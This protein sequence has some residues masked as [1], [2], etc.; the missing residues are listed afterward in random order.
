MQSVSSYLGSR[1]S[2]WEKPISEAVGKKI[3]FLGSSFYSF[4][5]LFFFLLAL[6]VCCFCCNVIPV[7]KRNALQ[8]CKTTLCS[9]DER[10]RESEEII[11]GEIEL[12]NCFDFFF[13]F[14]RASTV[15]GNMCRSISSTSLAIFPDFSQPFI[16]PA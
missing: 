15:W 10:K 3:V 16:L 5:G 9:C 13:F 7:R 11:H 12:F 4:L 1:F 6:T 2:V 8:R 14:M